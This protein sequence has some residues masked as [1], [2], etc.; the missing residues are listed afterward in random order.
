MTFRNSRLTAVAATSAL[1][2]ITLTACAGSGDTAAN[3][4]IA[5]STT[6]ATS[7]SQSA[8]STSSSTTTSPAATST[9]TS[10]TTSSATSAPSSSAKTSAATRAAQTTRVAR[11]EA[12]PV[13]KTLTETRVLPFDTVTRTDSTL[14]KGATRVAQAGVAGSQRVT[15]TQ[16]VVNGRITNVNVTK[17]VTVAQPVNKIVVVGTKAAAPRVTSTPTTTTAPKTNTGGLDLRRAGMWDRIAMCESTGNWSINTG[18][19]YYGGLQFD[20][21]TWLSAGGG[22][23]A[24]RADLASRAQQITI[25]NKVYDS[26]G[27][28]PWGCVGAA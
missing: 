13:F 20:I 9:T 17:R 1:A 11:S 24:P 16:T 14:A 10:S 12:R 21:G 19:G 25:A 27:L 18:N 22:Q 8:P 4:P 28:S 15:V 2:A 26:R 3:T 23:F 5:T 6:A 7:T